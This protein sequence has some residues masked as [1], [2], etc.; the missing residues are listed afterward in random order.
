M[1]QIHVT[2][3]KMAT[4]LCHHELLRLLIDSPNR[5]MKIQIHVTRPK[6]A[7]NLCHHELLRNA[8]AQIV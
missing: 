3:P 5:L 6:I 8:Y 7:T 4:S 1:I 2:R